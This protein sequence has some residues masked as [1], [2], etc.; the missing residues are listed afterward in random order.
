M[1]KMI[2]Q[3]AYG[4]LALSMLAMMLIFSV[5]A[6]DIVLKENG[7]TGIE[8]KAN[9]YQKLHFSNSL[10][11]LKA[12]KVD[13]ESGIF[14]ELAVRGYSATAV[15]G[16]PKLPVNRKLIEIPFGATVSVKILD[17]EV[18]EYE[19]A[20]LGIHFPLMPAQ[21]PAP[22]DGSYV[23]FEYDAA[24][25]ALDAYTDNALVSVE[26][27]GVMRGL[28]VARL[29]IAPVQYNP[30]TGMI[31]VYTGIEAE[32]IFE[33]ADVPLTL[34]NKMKNQAPYFRSA[35]KSLLNYKYEQQATR[36]TITRYPVKFV[37]VS[38]RMFEAQLQPYIEWKTMKG[39][40]VVEAY[41]DEPAVGNTT[42]SIKTYLQG[43]YDAGTPDD[44]SPSFV[45][46]VG[47]VA[48]IPAWNGNAGWHVTDLRYVEY[49]GD[50]FPEVYYGRWS[51]T[52]PSELQPQID[53]TLQYEQYTMPDPSY[54]D[55][56]V[57]VAGMDSGHGNDWANGQI[58][59]GTENY[60][61]LAHGLT[62]HTY[63]YPQSGSHSA[64]I[65]QNVSDG[66]SYG[67]YTAHCSANGWADPSFTISDVAGLQN[68][69]EYGVLVGNCCSSNEFD[70]YCFGEA[71]LRA[72]N[73]GAVGYIGGTNS[74]YWDEDYYFGVGV[75]AISE[76]P[77][78]YEETTLGFYDRAFH[79]HGEPWEDW[80]TTTYQMIFAGNLAVTE[81]SPSMAE[82][83]WEIYSVMGDPSLMCY[84]GVPDPLTVSHDPLI[85][86]GATSFTVNTEPYAY[87][88]L[89]MDGV[90]YGAALADATGVALLTL[91]PMTTPGE[92]DVVATKQNFQP[93]IGTVLVNNPAGPYIAMSYYVIQDPTGNDNGQADYGE[94][95][96]LDV[97]LEN[98]G[99]DDASDVTGVLSSAD[100]YITIT[101]DF[102][103]W[104]LIPAGETSM[105]FDAFAF[106]VDA[107][108]P[109]QHIAAFQLDIS[110]TGKEEWQS[111]FSIVLHAP[112]MGT[113]TV[114]VDDTQSGN[115]NGRLDPGETADI[116]V[117]VENNG[118][119]DAVNALASLSSTSGDIVINTGTANISNI[120]AGGEEDAV[121]NVTVDDGIDPGTSISFEFNVEAEGYMADLDFFLVAGQIPVLILDFDVN[122]SSGLEM[123]NCLSNLSVGAD[124]ATSMPDNLQLYSSVFVCLG[125][126][127]SN[128][129]LSATEGQLLADY[130]DGG[131]NLYMEGGDTWFYDEPTAVHPMFGITGQEDGSDDL[132][133]I[134]G[135]EGTFTEGMSFS[136]SG[137]NNWIDHIAPN[138][139]AFLIFENQSPVYGTGVAN[140]GET[141]RTIGCSHEF[142]GIDNGAFT[143]D[144]LMYKYLEF[145]GIDATWVGVDEM[146]LSER[147][148]SIYPNPARQSVN[149][150]VTVEKP[151]PLSISVFN[152]TG[153]EI[154]RLADNRQ[155]DEGTHLFG[156]DVS[157]LPGGVYHCVLTSGQE[158]ISSKLVVIR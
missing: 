61:N 64:D 120:A 15:I 53:K 108:I 151:G 40:T 47:D 2:I 130:L 30:V 139:S 157:N 29:D 128:H 129:S 97:L 35:G 112:V 100:E 146:N 123:N 141:Y 68:Q 140:I 54:L 122:F 71:L 66:V 77:P 147:M 19:L 16:A 24:A 3:N 114:S 72:E 104:G 88:A 21:P 20:T 49:T 25:Y 7:K 31:R 41:T 34:E 111:T 80:Y 154:R 12:F 67:N 4:R 134:L 73:K 156:L 1:R 110:G 135:Q 137:E 82:Y 81:G 102:A 60:F 87:V 153:Q 115:G 39:F 55:E 89:S 149:V 10:D 124:Y 131:G 152:N 48:Q 23:P 86:M 74:T 58:N 142:G 46:F 155:L 33:G 107:M 94:T 8:V 6:R 5:S 150:F 84:F 42:N 98:L 44:P 91:D 69:D 92:A 148:I 9:T 138:G 28:R 14:S 109:D 17:Y 51:A 70:S 18:V 43:L 101:D 136:Y 113:G 106:D 32:V 105:Q 121:F 116:I 144:Y 99:G 50:D 119:C 133:T 52:N 126:Y 118:H 127:S 158:R 27:L 95:I 38:D 37:I 22:K 117:P 75:G 56:V 145:F 26:V 36:D 132:G 57:M 103:E 93:Y 76:D 45:L 143:Q 79:D 125:I 62:S 90:L 59:Y 85:P 13:T 65:I 96:S 11:M 63:L 83:Y 78:A